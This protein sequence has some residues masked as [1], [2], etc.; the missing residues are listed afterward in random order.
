M[1]FSSERDA[2]LGNFAQG[3]LRYGWT[4]V[5]ELPGSDLAF[6]VAAGA[7]Y[8]VSPPERKLVAEVGHALTNVFLSPENGLVVAHDD[9]RAYVL[10]PDGEH[11]ST[12]RISIDGITNTRVV[13]DQLVGEWFDPMT[14]KWNPFELDLH[15]RELRGGTDWL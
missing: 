3:P 10:R 1:E 14:E 7:G 5:C 15:T 9:W 12:R 11:W 8:L 2:W 6:V 4:G 13:L